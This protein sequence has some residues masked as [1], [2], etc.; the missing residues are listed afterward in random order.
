[1]R[2]RL[3]APKQ[4]QHHEEAHSCARD[5]NWRTPQGYP[6]FPLRWSQGEI[7][8][9]AAS[10]RSQ[11]ESQGEKKQNNRHAI[12]VTLLFPFPSSKRSTDILFIHT[13]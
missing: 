10:D 12:A 3:C 13:A 1:M 4:P 2:R 5:H 8:R 7:D 9:A 11:G 6:G